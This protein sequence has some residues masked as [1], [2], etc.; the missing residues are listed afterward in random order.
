MQRERE[1]FSCSNG[2]PHSSNLLT[3][4]RRVHISAQMPRVARVWRTG[5]MAY[6]STTAD[7][8]GC[9]QLPTACGHADLNLS[10]SNQCITMATPPNPAQGRRTAHHPVLDQPGTHPTKESNPL[11]WLCTGDTTKK[12]GFESMHGGSNFWITPHVLQ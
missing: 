6:L 3:A 2:F 7:G 9:N 5:A 4:T 12:E 10:H 11:W 1:V 8:C